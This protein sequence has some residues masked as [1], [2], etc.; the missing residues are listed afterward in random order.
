MI[1]SHQNDN[2][3]LEAFCFLTC[4]KKRFILNLYPNYTKKF[5]DNIN[6]LSSEKKNLPYL[7]ISLLQVPK[8]FSNAT[9]VS[10]QCFV[11]LLMAQD[12]KSGLR[13]RSRFTEI[14]LIKHF[15]K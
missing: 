14:L 6:Y 4:K 8:L 1:S 5:K 2:A 7:G 12:Y 11:K 13:I 3:I 10:F 9:P 15:M